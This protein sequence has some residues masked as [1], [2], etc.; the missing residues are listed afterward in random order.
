MRISRV[1]EAFWHSNLNIEAAQ[2]NLFPVIAFEG[3]SH[4]EFMSGTPPLLV[5]NKD[6]KPDVSESDAHVMVSKAMVEFFDQII[7]GNKISLNVAA[8]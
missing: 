4:A 7:F 8:S 1:A 6:L 2:K 5:K 3:V